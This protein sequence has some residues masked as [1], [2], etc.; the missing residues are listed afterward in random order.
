MADFNTEPN[1][2]Q[3]E[4]GIGYRGGHAIL[5]WLDGLTASTVHS[6]AS[7]LDFSRNICRVTTVANANDSGRLPLG[8]PGLSLNVINAGANNMQVYTYQS[9][10]TINGIAGSTG[11][12]Q[13]P[14]SNVSYYC[15]SVSPTTG[16][17]TWAAQD[18]G[19]GTNGN[20]PTLGYQTSLTAGTTQTAAGGTPITSSIAEFDTVATNANSATLPPAQPGMQITVINNDAS[21]HTLQIFAATAALGGVAGGDTINGSTSF[22]TAAAPIVTLV[23]CTKQGIW[24]TK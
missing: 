11:V 12:S 22:T 2:E 7:K 20:Y 1:T 3:R 6:N 8:F 18:L 16:V 21:N 14:G 10:D 5:G 24:L 15:T 19:V 9:A 4:A 23:F 17:A 13:M